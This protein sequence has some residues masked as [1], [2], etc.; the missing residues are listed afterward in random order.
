VIE[1]RKMASPALMGQVRNCRKSV[2]FCKSAEVY[3]SR[4]QCLILA[5]PWGVPIY[6]PPNHDRLSPNR[7]S[8]AY[9]FSGRIAKLTTSLSK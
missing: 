2:F 4:L 8:P 9:F 1:A 6:I 3:P 7:P 5:M